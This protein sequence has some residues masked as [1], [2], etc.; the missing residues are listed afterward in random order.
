MQ[1]FLLKEI[2]GVAG[3]PSEGGNKKFVVI[4]T[5]S[6]EMI[7]ITRPDDLLSLVFCYDLNSDLVQ[8]DSEAGELNNKKIQGLIAR[9]GQEHKLSL[10]CKQPL[11]VEGP[12]DVMI[13]SALSNRADMH[14][15]AAG[16]Q[17]L[18]VIG[19]GQ[20]P[21]VTKLLRLLGKVPVS[22]AD[23][24]AFADGLE[25]VNQFLSD[26][27]AANTDAANLGFA[28]ATAMAKGIYDDFCKLTQ[29]RWKDIS[30]LA[31]L[32]PYWLNRKAGEDELAKRRAAF[33][34]LFTASDGDLSR[35]ASDDAWVSIKR[36]V[37]A[38]LDVLEKSGLFILRKGS[39][40]SYYQKS[41]QHTSI[42]KPSAA[43]DEMEYISQLDKASIHEPYADILRCIQFASKA[44]PICEA[45]ALRDL[46]LA[47]AAPAHARL[48]AGDSAKDF[49]VLARSILGERSKI[50]DLTV[51]DG[52]LVIAI[53]SNI[54]R[55][56]GFPLTVSKDDDA[57]K[58]ISLALA[59]NA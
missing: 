9:L 22:L 14:L 36:R 49:N 48:K 25:L 41:D 17:L 32:H 34:T 47:V 54:L 3:H 52:S 58:V 55:I 1:A 42:G 2:I 4:A 8:I 27:E 15:E 18:P 5:H 20:M 38:V 11:L 46:L 50:F 33:C 29:N 43:A 40:E 31:E 57:A 26:C 28:S 13:C 30:G 39:I 19:K 51:N 37:S 6:T 59:S 35:I 56:D 23:A 44:D 12:S 24:D 45:D 21:I 16:S 53:A 10:F 7:Q